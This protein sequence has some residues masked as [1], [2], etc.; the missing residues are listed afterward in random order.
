MLNF[1]SYPMM[2]NTLTQKFAKITIFVLALLI[3][4]ADVCA[5]AT[6]VGPFGKRLRDKDRQ[7]AKSGVSFFYFSMGRTAVNPP[8]HN[9]LFCNFT[10][11]NPNN[12]RVLE[13]S[14]PAFS[15]S[16]LVEYQFGIADIHTRSNFVIDLFNYS[17]ARTENKSYRMDRISSGLGYQF[18]LGNNVWLRQTTYLS[19][20]WLGNTLI[21][22]IDVDAPSLWFND[23]V[24]TE[25]GSYRLLIRQTQFSLRPQIG[26]V[27]GLGRSFLV[28]FNVGYIHSFGESDPKILLKPMNDS[29]GELSKFNL[30]ADR[31][32]LRDSNN[33]P[34]GASSFLLGNWYANIR[35]GLHIFNN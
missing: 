22:T 33:T 13:G 21:R 24:F 19:A 20:E 23:E 7:E 3:R 35:L 16:H 14:L 18:Q 6:I 4:Y 27:A 15:S 26:L 32:N 2:N 12:P 28:S 8:G 9:G 11:D 30:S 5:Q 34:T 1:N 17:F 31:I 25:S 29:E 10:D